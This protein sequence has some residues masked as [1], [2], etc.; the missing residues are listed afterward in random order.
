MKI[1][2][3][4]I[5]SILGNLLFNYEAEDAT[6]KKAAEQ[7]IKEKVDL[8]GAYLHGADL[9]GAYLDGAYLDGAYLHGAS[10]D[11]ADLRSADLRG[12]DL[13]G[14]SLDGAYLRGAYLRGADLRGA[15]LRSADLRGADLRGAKNKETANLPI[16]CKWSATVI[17][18]KIQIGC[19]EKTI[20][21][22]DSFFASDEI[23]E[24]QRGTDDFKQIQ[25]TYEAY[26]A[27]LTFLNT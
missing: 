23:Y 20:E 27:Y 3:I 5:K 6:I 15:D 26:K 8:R 24:T 11:G 4:E 19:K 16:H 1:I 22:W 2:K 25:A 17:G 13:D 21:E 10:L 9:R 14:A 7:A 18:N 12:A